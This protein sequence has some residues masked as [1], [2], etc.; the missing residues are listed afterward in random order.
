MKGEKKTSKTKD[1]KKKVVIEDNFIDEDDDKRVII[2]IAIALLVIIGIIIGL[3][4]GCEKVEEDPVKP[5]EQQDIVL[6]D[7]EEE[8]EEKEKSENKPIV[9]KVTTIEETKTNSTYEIVFYY[10]NLEDTYRTSVKEGNKVSKYLPEGFESCKYYKNSNF[11]N[12]FNFNDGIYENKN[13]YMDCEI[14]EYTIIYDKQTTNP[15]TYTVL[16]GT[17]T[18]TNPTTENIF[19][20]WYLDEN[21]TTKVTKLSSDIISYA[22]DKI[23][24]IYGK[25]VE[26]LNINYYNDVND[27]ESHEEINKEQKDNYSVHSGNDYCTIEGNFLGWTTVNGSKTI[28]Y[29]EGNEISLN[30]DLN[31]YPVCAAVKVIYESENESVEVGYTLDD[32]DTYEL[33]TPETLGMEV[34][35]YYV[36]VDEQ[37]QT[38]KTVVENEKENILDNE[39]KLDDVI[40]DASETYTPEVGDNVESL[41][42]VFAGWETDLPDPEDE[43]NMITVD[44]PDDFVPED[45]E[46]KLKAKWIEESQVDETVNDTLDTQMPEPLTDNAPANEIPN[47]NVNEMPISEEI[48]VI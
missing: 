3:I 4:A 2:F 41:E 40:N 27:L 17:I 10:N 47:E 26:Y 43:E 32:L 35:T 16:D 30:D 34:P 33:P 42:K 24:Y 22:K 20:G 1:V 21:Y 39:I 29:N 7:V 48:P 36:K 8:K 19:T 15:T 11:T 31:L 37:T 46:T 28:K 6:P 5:S 9:K 14:T 18:L 38:S 45:E 12:E 25:E 13:I 23:I 44:V